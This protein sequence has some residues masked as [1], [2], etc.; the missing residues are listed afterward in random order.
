MGGGV[1]QL[2]INQT[3][4]QKSYRLWVHVEDEYRQRL[5]KRT[6]RRLLMGIDWD[7]S[8]HQ[9]CYDTHQDL[10]GHMCDLFHLVR[11]RFRLSLVGMPGKSTTNLGWI[12]LTD[13]I[14]RRK[15]CPRVCFHGVMQ[16]RFR[17][18]LL[19]LFFGVVAPSWY[20]TFFNA[21]HFRFSA[22]FSIQ[23]SCMLRTSSPYE[24]KGDGAQSTGHQLWVWVITHS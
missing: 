9:C 19:L 18:S 14:L 3:A 22:P 5:K 4:V 8:G 13:I 1:K 20:V 11:S 24:A 7:W 12:A 6:L 23:V 2:S 21:H 15:K 17:F 16:R 10:L